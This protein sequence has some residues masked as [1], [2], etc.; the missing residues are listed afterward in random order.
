MKDYHISLTKAKY[1]YYFTDKERLQEKADINIINKK[2]DILA[3][4]DF[5]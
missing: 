1:K 3:K 4:L 5:K 2:R